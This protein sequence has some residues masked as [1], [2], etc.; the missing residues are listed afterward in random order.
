MRMRFCWRDRRAGL[1]A[2]Q[3][4]VRAAVLLAHIVHVV[5]DDQ[6]QPELLGP[7]HQRL[8]DRDQFG[9][10][11]LLQLDKEVLVAKDVDVPAQALVGFLLFALVEQ[12]RHLGAQAAGGADQP[13]GVRG[14][15]VVV[16]ARL[17]VVAVQLGVR[18]D[19]EQVAIA[20]HVLGQ[21][22]QVVVLLVE[23]RRRGRPWAR[24]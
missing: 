16:D 2:E 14:Q 7:G 18:G 6:L 3:H 24:P 9:D 23:L 13:F 5:G 10:D 21:Q 19:L 8:V 20:G 12:L 11:V 4:V 22:Q 1:H 17:V 15:K